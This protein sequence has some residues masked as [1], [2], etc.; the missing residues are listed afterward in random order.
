LCAI[1][2]FIRTH[3]GDEG[4]VEGQDYNELD[5]HGAGSAGSGVEGDL[6]EDA[7]QMAREFRDQLAQEMWNDY[8]QLLQEGGYLDDDDTS[9]GHAEEE[10]VDNG[11]DLD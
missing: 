2:N 11:L 7:L 10:S 1:H 5:E 4:L 3:D 6:A 9:L 8:Q